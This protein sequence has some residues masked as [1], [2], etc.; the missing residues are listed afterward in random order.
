MRNLVILNKGNIV[1]E[2]QYYPDLEPGSFQYDTIFDVVTN[3]LIFIL[4]LYNEGIVEIQ[5][6]KRTGEINL[7]ANFPLS[8]TDSKVLSL[9]HFVDTCQIILTYDNGDIVQITYDALSNDPDQS[10]IEIVG[11]IDVGL[12]AASWSPDDETLALITKENKMLLLS[13]SFDPIAEKI[14]NP[15]DIKVSRSKHVS[16]GWGKAETQFR[17]KGA[18]AMEREKLLLQN[19]GLDLKDESSPLRDPTVLAPQDGKV[20]D[21]DNNEVKI[22]WRADCECFSVNTRESV[23]IEETNGETTVD[24]NQRRVLRVFSRHGELESV[25]E[26][27][28]GLEFN[29]AWKP[30][31]AVIAS[32][33]RHLDE[34]GEPVLDVIFFERNGL[35]RY[36][37]NSRL[38]PETEII[39]DI[40]WSCDSEILAIQLFDRIQLW[41]TKNFH[42][43]LKSEIFVNK[44]DPLNQVEFI[45]FHPEKP[46]QFLIGTSRQGVEIVDLAH[47]IVSGPTQI[48]NDVGMT[49][50]T[51][52]SEVKITPLGIANVPPPVSFRELEIN[53]NINDL[54]VS[55]S[56]EI[57][58]LLTSE[59]NIHIGYMKLNKVKTKQ[60]KIKSVIKQSEFI[61][62][63][64]FV[65][66]TAILGDSILA[67]LVDAEDCSS[68]MAFDITNL[69]DPQFISAIQ[70]P[71][72]AVLLKSSADFNS[73][74]VEHIDKTVTQ[75]DA[76]LN[77]TEITQFP[78]LCRDFEVV[79]NE[80][81]EGKLTAFGITD[82]G[83]LFAND[84]QVAVGVTS[85]KVTESHLLFTTVQSKLC[86]IHINSA[87]DN[88][89]YDI[90]QNDQGDAQVDERIRYIERGSI[91]ISA[92]PSTYQVVLQA[93]RG[94]LE[95][96]C[97]RIM[98]L[99]GVRKFIQQKKFYDAF[100][101]CRVHRI[102]L[103]LLHDF[104]KELFFNNLENFV[105]QIS[106]IDY[107]DLFLSGL[108]E[109]DVTSTKYKDTFK[110][111][112][113]KIDTSV[114]EVKPL[115]VKT[116]P[117]L[118]NKKIII[119]KD[120][121]IYNKDSKVNK[122]CNGILSILLKPEYLSK[123]L[124]TVLTAYAC[125]K[126]PNLLD[127]LKLI[128]TFTQPEQ[129][130]QSVIH[131]CFLSDVNKLYDVALSLY[132]VKL[133]LQIAQQSQK[134]P[135]EYLPFLQNLHI[136]PPKRKEFM[137]DDH[138]KN[139]SKALNWLYELGPEVQDEF[140]DYLIKHEL[141][142]EAL[143][144]YQYNQDNARIN[145]ILNMFAQYLRNEKN[146]EEA[147]I[148]F[149]SLGDDKDALDCYILGKHWKNA[150]AIV[151][152]VEFN[153]EMIESAET[154]VESLTA[155]HKYSDAGF[156]EYNF[157]N[158]LENAMKLYCKQYDY[159]M[160]ILL[161]TK[162]KK[163]ELI[164][165]VVD[166]QLSEGFGTIA[167]L[168]ADFKGQVNS[169]LKRL[170]ELRTKK[171]EDPYA[172]YGIP[173]DDLDTPDNVSVAAS[174]YSANPSFFTRYT[175][176]TQGTAKTGASRKTAK[177]RKREER[178]RAKGR[179]GTIYEEEYLIKSVG[180]L[181]ERMDQTHPDAIN[182]I[183]NLI[184]RSM[185]PQ[186]YQIQKSWVDLIDLLRE[187]IEEIY[188]ME[189][190]DRE[191]IDD[192]GELYL[193][194]EIPIPNINDFPIKHT[195]D[196]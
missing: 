76:E 131:L 141:Y 121:N 70:L 29:L 100:I 11:S 31:G 36:E 3:S 9:S 127:G 83:K 87:S 117:S 167:E 146:F 168:L 129:I 191:R 48:G 38:N 6:H 90:F 40:Q 92:I 52:G 63:D 182:L 45:K 75:L 53:E 73:L 91:L 80:E 154:L 120:R 139:Y 62:S 110:E 34:E 155:D 145:Q 133:T 119:N 147:G 24:E 54:A 71:N 112:D 26:A 132:D 21:F 190:R 22:S 10:I 107:L 89:Q 144:I 17:G 37:F 187:N 179:K 185:K 116:D 108:H 104:D 186:A 84:V 169:Q 79:R 135:K 189:E 77:E 61:L 58:S 128:G 125:Q 95:T 103:D 124:Q 85:I 174:E 7:L 109:E 30:T 1:P 178:K 23:I 165:T 123:Y 188:K 164:E 33:W 68:I 25:S 152:K 158:N 161:A 162:D 72:K 106:R 65:K 41:T 102:D 50:V 99:A 160:A 166:K 82:T 4:H 57:F 192:N 170:R 47:K 46:Q 14:L 8:Q 195:L 59:G 44:V 88:Y 39:Q 137:I 126:P 81:N 20:S 153:D 196:Y 66:Q 18:R 176:K 143:K 55:K 56:N 175:G 101:A 114:P 12:K 96:I 43:Y 122:I 173:N 15:D 2:S 67:I 5:Q 149:E 142:K 193:I 74:I 140:D 60:P 93:Q 98:V 148:T 163:L 16:V 150:M 32:S 156:I 136:Q 64:E 111:A 28:D 115:V 78:Q 134:D 184:K 138:L 180:R 19:A 86:F 105:N 118:D 181:I 94:N 172:F 49:L 13:R 42:W 97:P 151:S 35:K 157:L 171:K 177:N 51:D 194:P 159:N 130:E 113:G 27:Y 183:D 69:E